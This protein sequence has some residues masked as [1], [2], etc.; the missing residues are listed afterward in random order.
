MKFRPT[1]AFLAL[2]A[3]LISGAA[4][5][6]TSRAT[7]APADPGAAKLLALHASLVPR[8]VGNQFG[9]PLAME[10]VKTSSRVSGD[11]YAEVDTSFQIVRNSFSNPRTWCDVLILHVNTKFCRAGMGVDAN[12]LSVRLGKK[13]PQ[14]LSEAFALEFVF[15]LRANREGYMEAW[16]TAPMGPLGT[17]DYKFELQAVPLAGN[18][19]FLRLHYSYAYGG[20]ASLATRG[21]LASS[22]RGKVGF[23]RVPAGAGKYGYIDGMRGVVERNTMRYYLAVD[24]YLESLAQAPG[25]QFSYRIA[26]W[27]DA[28]EEYKLQLHEMN[29]NDYLA[30]KKSEY[31]RQQSAVVR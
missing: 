28:T 9:R 30:M 13:S 10:S 12:Q 27:F 6:A 31:L 24:S 26:H 11:I 25:R 23:T 14:E 4:L 7:N 3:L 17:E 8:L 20:M 18:R 29:R 16:L 1:L 19:S 2:A 5:G 21:Y 22:G 15:Q